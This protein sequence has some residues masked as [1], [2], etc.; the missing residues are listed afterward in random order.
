MP[1]SNRIEDLHIDLNHVYTEAKANFI[2]AHPERSKPRLG[3]THRPLNVQAAYFAQGRQDLAAI[4][5]LRKAAGLYLIG[6]EE[7]KVVITNAKPGQSAHQRLPSYAFDV[8]F[9]DAKGNADWS[10]ENFN[11]FAKYVTAAAIKLKVAISQGAY[12]KFKDAPHTELVG[13]QKVN[14]A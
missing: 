14:P 10:L 2:A 3:E 9:L 1:T 13:W 4:N 8:M 6:P 12:W 7:A 11:L 5:A